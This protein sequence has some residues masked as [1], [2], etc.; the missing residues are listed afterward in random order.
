MS[1][2]KLPP[3]EEVVRLYHDGL[4]C[5]QIGE[6]FS[7]SETAVRLLLKRKS[8]SRRPKS[9]PGSRSAESN[10]RHSLAIRGENNG[11]YIHGKRVTTYRSMTDHSQCRHCGSRNKVAVHHIDGDHYNNVPENLVALC[12]SCHVSGHK[13]GEKHHNARLTAVEVLEIRSAIGVTHA[14]LAD[15]Y[16]VS[17]R[18]VGDIIARRKWKHLNDNE[19]E[20]PDGNTEN[21]CRTVD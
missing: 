1:C 10:A 4:S 3:D 7:A 11:R 16:G 6:M 20:I 8:I 19:K 9:Y 15:R 21:V 17:R 2:R 14:C 5:R 12:T 13:A 18:H